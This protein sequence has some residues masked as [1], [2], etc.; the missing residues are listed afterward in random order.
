VPEPSGNLLD[1][2]TLVGQERDVGVAEVVDADGVQSCGFGVACV[3]LGECAVTHGAGGAADSVVFCET[4]EFFL[5]LLSVFIKAPSTNPSS[6]IPHLWHI[7]H[8]E[9]TQQ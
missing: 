7:T 2:D 5:A 3:S 6:P 4:G 8:T 1:V 9:H